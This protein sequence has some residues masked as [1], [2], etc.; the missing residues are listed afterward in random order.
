MSVPRYIKGDK[1]A[2]LISPGYGAGWST[3]ASDNQAETMLFHPTIAKWVEDGK[4]GGEFKIRE[5]LG[6]LFEEDDMPYVGG[7]DGLQIEWLDEGM[8]FDVTEYDG[9]ERLISMIKLPFVA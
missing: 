1:V 7:W 6:L 3:W 5:I 4:P 8:A 2:V 9:S